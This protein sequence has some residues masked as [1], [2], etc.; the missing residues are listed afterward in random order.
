M[1]A[2]DSYIIGSHYLATTSEDRDLVFAVVI[3]RIAYSAY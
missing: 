3:A 2:E 1:E